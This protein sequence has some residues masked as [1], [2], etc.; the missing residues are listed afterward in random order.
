MRADLVGQLEHR[1][2]LIAAF[3]VSYLLLL[4]VIQVK[5]TIQDALKDRFYVKHAAFA[6]GAYLYKALFGRIR[7]V[8]KLRALVVIRCPRQYAKLRGGI[9]PIAHALAGIE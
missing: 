7:Y 1:L 6:T 3:A 8:R 5:I 4:R 2:W 9:P